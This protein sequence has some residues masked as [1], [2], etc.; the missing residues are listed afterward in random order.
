MEEGWRP[1]LPVHEPYRS[2]IRSVLG[3]PQLFFAASLNYK[4]NIIRS[5]IRLILVHIGQKQ[6]VRFFL[7]DQ[8]LNLRVPKANYLFVSDWFFS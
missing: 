4:K 1:C 5:I 2:T 3:K 8:K 6:G 7:L